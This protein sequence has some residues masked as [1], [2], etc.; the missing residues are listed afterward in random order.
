MFQNPANVIKGH[1]GKARVARSGKEGFS[2]LPEALMGM[3]PRA[4]ISKDRLG[5]KVTVLPC[6]LATFLM[7]YLYIMSLS[8]IWVRGENRISISACPAVATSWCW[9]RS[10][11]LSSP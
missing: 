5:M 7:M 1:V 3:H 11:C 6:L 9:P 10:R 4:V 2:S 8:A